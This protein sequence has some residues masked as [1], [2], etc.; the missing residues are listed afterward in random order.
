MAADIGCCRRALTQNAA[1]E[2]AD[3]KQIQA[4]GPSAAV[5]GL[6]TRSARPFCMHLSGAPVLQIITKM[7]GSPP[8]LDA[9]PEEDEASSGGQQPGTHSERHHGAHRLATENSIELP[10]SSKP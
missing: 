2:S 6:R 8:K 7:G 9:T 1:I 10:S 5:A 3:L 4:G